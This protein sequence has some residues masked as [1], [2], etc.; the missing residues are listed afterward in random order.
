MRECC[1]PEDPGA[2]RRRRW[3]WLGA[4]LAVVGVIALV[5]IC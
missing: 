3:F 1:E 2:V 4:A 5:Q